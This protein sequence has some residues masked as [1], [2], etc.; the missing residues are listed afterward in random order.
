ML[1]F[2]V[3]FP[4]HSYFKIYLLH[5]VYFREFI[6]SLQRQKAVYFADSHDHP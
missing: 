4:L 6:M 3:Y 1:A 2:Y 5:Y